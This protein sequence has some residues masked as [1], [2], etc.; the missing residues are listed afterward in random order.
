MA[1]D[2][3]FL[4]IFDA[5]E[6]HVIVLNYWEFFMCKL[7]MA[8]M[9]VLVSLVSVPASARELKTETPRVVPR[10]TPV[11]AY[12]NT[13]WVALAVS[14]NGRVF[15]SD[16][17]TSEDRARGEAKNECEQNSGWTC[18]DTM[19]VPDSWD[20]IVLR[21]G[22]RNFLGGSSQGKAHDIALDKAAAE[23]FTANRCRQIANY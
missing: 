16:S 19:S 12:G 10:E 8:A 5:R 3:G 18:R 9:A 17:Y 14:P 22:N 21:C 20:V 23:G 4:L 1:G 11:V 13:S 7:L 6:G 15:Q 2:F